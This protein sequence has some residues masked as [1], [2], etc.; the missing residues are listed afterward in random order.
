[1]SETMNPPGPEAH[2][3]RGQAS[4]ETPSL[5]LR[6]ERAKVRLRRVEAGRVRLGKRVIRES[7]ALEVPV[8]VDVGVVVER[9]PVER[10][11]G[12]PVSE[13]EF[14]VPVVAEAVSTGVR[15][16]VYERVYATV[17]KETVREFVETAVRRETVD[18]ERE[19][20]GGEDAG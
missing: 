3:R 7:Q 16:R 17:E 13:G 8:M 6:E 10:R 11:S 1:M 4:S 18:L 19:P 15:A 5:E 2:D 9:R 14:V 12:S 20:L